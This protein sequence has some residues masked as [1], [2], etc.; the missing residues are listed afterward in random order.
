MITKNDLRK[1]KFYPMSHSEFNDCV[2]F[3]LRNSDRAV[4][5]CKIK[6]EQFFGGMADNL[7][8]ALTF[9][10]KFY[11]EDNSV[12]VSIADVR[13]GVLLY[14]KMDILHELKIIS[15]EEYDEFIQSNSMFDDEDY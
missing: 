7:E 3:A 11:E 13:K 12:D 6:D 9:C 4:A 15:E 10:K 8:D 14:G 2:A 1:D 5:Y